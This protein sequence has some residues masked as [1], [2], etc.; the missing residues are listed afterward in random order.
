ML[1]PNLTFRDALDSDSDRQSSSSAGQHDCGND[2]QRTSATCANLGPVRNQSQSASRASSRPLAITSTLPSERFRALTARPRACPRRWV[3]TR[4]PTPWTRPLMVHRRHSSAIGSRQ[5]PLGLRGALPGAALVTLLARGLRLVDHDG[6]VDVGHRWNLARFQGG[7]E[8]AKS[9]RLR[10][11]PCALRSTV[12]PESSC[13]LGKVVMIKWLDCSTSAFRYSC[14][15]R[16]AI[17]LVCNEIP[18]WTLRRLFS[19]EC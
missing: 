12:G 11:P 18:N 17:E 10:Q 3:E 19:E 1:G 13:C 14:S 16:Q 4:K 2:S 15:N 6:R 9:G 8:A 7:S 5:A